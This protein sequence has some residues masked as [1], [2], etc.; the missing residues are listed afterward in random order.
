MK[1]KRGIFVYIP[2]ARRKSVQT[3]RDVIDNEGKLL[4]DVF[5][6]MVDN[7]LKER[8]KQTRLEKGQE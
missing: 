3:F 1:E 7:Y 4:C 2:T 6:D 5:C 8:G